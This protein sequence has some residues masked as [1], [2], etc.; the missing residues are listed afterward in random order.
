MPLARVQD[1]L[2]AGP[3]Q[4]ARGDRGD[5]PGP[6]RRDP[7]AAAQPQTDRAP[8]PPATSLALPQSV[9]GYLD[10]LRGLGVDERYIELERDSWIMIAAQLPERIDA[11]IASKQESPRRPRHGAALPPAQRGARLARR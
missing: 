8:R 2:D 6:A 7:A 11:L 9:V 5:R 1:L 3:Q 4:F 10:R